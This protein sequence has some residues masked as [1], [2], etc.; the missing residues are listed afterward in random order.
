MDAMPFVIERG[1]VLSGARR[2]ERLGAV[3]SLR[4]HVSDISGLAF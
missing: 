1:P 3:A 4:I 2:V